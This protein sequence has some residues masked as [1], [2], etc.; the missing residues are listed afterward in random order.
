MPMRLT[1]LARL[2]ICDREHMAD[3]VPR[4]LYIC[5]EHTTIPND[6]LDAHEI[7]VFG[8]LTQCDREHMADLVSRILQYMINIRQYQDDT[9]GCF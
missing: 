3:L 2:T 4:I 6:A 1:Y 5:D 9:F 8:R 7:T